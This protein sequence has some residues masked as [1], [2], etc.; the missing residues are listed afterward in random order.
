MNIIKYQGTISMFYHIIVLLLLSNTHN[1]IVNMG[2]ND[3]ILF[4]VWVEFTIS[5]SIWVGNDRISLW[6]WLEFTI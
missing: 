6:V 3:R 5:L 1:I 4:H 2:V